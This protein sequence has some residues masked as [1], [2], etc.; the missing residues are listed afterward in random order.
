MFNR[1]MKLRPPLFRRPRMLAPGFLCLAGSLIAARAA[2]PQFSVVYDGKEG[3]YEVIRT[4]QLLVTKAG[5]YLAFAQGRSDQHDSADNDIIL[6]RSTDGGKSWS[7]L[8]VLVG[9]G[10]DSV[11][12]IC[13]VQVR[14]TGR[15]LLVGCSFPFGY[16]MRAFAQLSPALKNY[17]V[18]HKRDKNPAIRPGYEGNDIAR[19]Y[20]MFSDDD[21]K[22]WSPTR[23]ITRIAKPPAPDLAAA[24]GP[25]FSIQLRAGKHAGRIVVPFYSWRIP[26]APE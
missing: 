19:N 14:E 3:K 1:L 6:K 16:E 25:G 17:Q 9:Q 23:D 5:T 21:G 8:Q 13:V 10:Q 12:S 20:D 15:I 22:T 11:N 2:E 7:K 4:P 26:P 24:P 18:E